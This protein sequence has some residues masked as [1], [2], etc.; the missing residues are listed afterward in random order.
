MPRHRVDRTGLQFGRLTVIEFSH[1][2]VRRESYWLCQCQCGV[3]KAVA[4]GNLRS[5]D[6]KS[7]G[8]LHDAVAGKSRRTHG[9][10]QTRTYR[11]WKAMNKRCS[12]PASPK[13]HR[14]GGR[15]IVVCSL[16]AS[17][18]EAF[19]VDMGECPLGQSI[20]RLN[21][22][23]PYAPWNCV[24]ATAAQQNRNKSSNRIV[25]AFGRKQTLAE[26]STETG[27][28]VSTI[29]HRLRDGVTPE[30]AVACRTP[31]LRRARGRPK[32]CANPLR[33]VADNYSGS[34]TGQDSQNPEIATSGDPTRK[35]ETAE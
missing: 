20:E 28:S 15:G 31:I 13:W 6:V 16:W 27:V 9:R 23:G 5:G 4:W 18:F 2:G 29:S 10:S 7:C 25:S 19:L 34:G 1:R 21:N 14:Y 32:K 30:E 35:L 33:L 17:S 8:C 11:I 24:W 26:W 22:D 12:N 3:R